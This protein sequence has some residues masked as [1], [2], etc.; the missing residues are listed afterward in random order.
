MNGTGSGHVGAVDGRADGVADAHGGGR[1]APDLCG[2]IQQEV[3][4][5]L[6][7]VGRPRDAWRG[8][9]RQVWQGVARTAP[10]A[11]G[12]SGAHRHVLWHLVLRCEEV[13]PPALLED[14]R[15]GLIGARV[16]GEAGRGRV[17]EHRWI[18]VGRTQAQRASPAAAPSA[19]VERYCS[20][21]TVDS[22]AI[23]VRRRSGCPGRTQRSPVSA[24]TSP[25]TTPR[26]PPADLTMGKNWGRRMWT[27]GTTRR[28]VGRTSGFRET[29]LTPR[30]EWRNLGP[31][32]RQEP[33]EPQASTA[34]WERGK[35][36]GKPQGRTG[37]SRENAAKR[38]RGKGASPAR[39]ARLEWAGGSDW[40]WSVVRRGGFP[41]A[42]G[43]GSGG[44]CPTRPR[45][46]ASGPS[47]TWPRGAR[48]A[49]AERLL[50]VA[51]RPGT[52]CPASF[53]SPRRGNGREGLDP[54][55]A[56]EVCP[57]TAGRPRAW[58]GVRR[59]PPGDS[60]RPGPGRGRQ[61]AS[62]RCSGPGRAER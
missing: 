10:L 38:D 53:H 27:L 54:A 21:E 24:P 43:A 17:R 16:D 41:G 15:V 37:G 45:H 58:P 51:S 59:L 14:E 13:V 52:F 33:A 23:R 32:R 2:E 62:R 61:G 6:R 4:A 40:R 44:G 26:L 20:G 30:C 57:A 47:K 36:E 42:A 46:G 9:G 7:H 50:G 55:G 31:V 22:S 5:E 28:K 3:S 11:D 29:A 35:P 48:E 34:R 49:S 39:G 8:P 19:P 1:R 12:V 60:A 25:R 18:E 56:V